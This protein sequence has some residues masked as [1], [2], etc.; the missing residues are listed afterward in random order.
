MSAYNFS[1]PSKK[2]CAS[3]REIEG[4]LQFRHCMLYPSLYMISTSKSCP[5][6]LDF[7]G[8]CDFLQE[9]SLVSSPIVNVKVP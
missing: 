7:I 2:Q 4:F 5:V 1:Y 8:V 9:M 6:H 3:L